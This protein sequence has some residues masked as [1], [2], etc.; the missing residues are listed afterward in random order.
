MAAVFKPGQRVVELS[1][2]HRK[3]T[4]RHVAGTGVNAVV[5][6]NLDGRPPANFR[7]AQIALI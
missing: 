3:G 2:P 1:P 7:P 4:V 6:V 5:T